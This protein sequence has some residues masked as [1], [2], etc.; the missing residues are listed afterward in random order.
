MK[1]IHKLP[2]IKNNIV[3]SDIDSLIRFLKKKTNFNTE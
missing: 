3:S 2:L 1:I